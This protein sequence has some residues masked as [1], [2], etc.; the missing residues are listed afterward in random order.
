MPELYQIAGQNSCKYLPAERQASITDQSLCH[1]FAMEREFAFTA[2]TSCITEM[3]GI[4]NAPERIVLL[5]VLARRNHFQIIR[6][7]AG[8]ASC[9]VLETFTAM[10]TVPLQMGAIATE[11]VK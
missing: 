7:Q 8:V 10:T 5:L 2:F 6:P 1:S 3:L 9:N 4:E 11:P